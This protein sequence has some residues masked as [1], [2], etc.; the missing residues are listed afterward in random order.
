ME[1]LLSDEEKVQAV[2]DCMQQGE[3]IRDVVERL[4]PDVRDLPTFLVR[5]TEGALRPLYDWDVLLRDGKLTDAA[6]GAEVTY[7]PR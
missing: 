7:R 3:S 4:P 6:T 5:D 2:I 1:K